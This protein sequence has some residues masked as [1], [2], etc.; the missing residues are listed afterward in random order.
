MRCLSKLAAAAHAHSTQP[1]NHLQRAEVLPTLPLA[2]QLE[3]PPLRANLP[4]ASIVRDG[5]HG[6]FVRGKGAR[7]RMKGWSL[8]M[9]A[10]SSMLFTHVA[11]AMCST[12]PARRSDR[13]RFALAP[14]R[15]YLFCSNA[16]RVRPRV[17]WGRFCTRYRIYRS[18]LRGHA[19]AEAAVAVPRAWTALGRRE[20]PF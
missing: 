16:S 17:F 19:V 11:R 6:S 9:Q 15:M 8:G 5:E 2:V 7:L 10:G 3:Q 4:N 14:K 20:V 12:L 18:D 13:S 1:A